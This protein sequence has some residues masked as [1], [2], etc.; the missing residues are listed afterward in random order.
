MWVYWHDFVGLLG[1]SFFLAFAIVQDFFFPKK[2]LMLLFGGLVF[3]GKKAMRQRGSVVWE[4]DSKDLL[5]S[6]R[7]GCS[8]KGAGE[9]RAEEMAPGVCNGHCLHRGKWILTLSSSFS[10]QKH[11]NHGGC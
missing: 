3:P 10:T 7:E 11:P 8:A 9:A 4:R 6:D 5:A 1:I 2:S